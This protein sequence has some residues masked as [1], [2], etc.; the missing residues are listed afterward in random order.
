FVTCWTGRSAGFSPLMRPPEGGACSL[1]CGRDPQSRVDLAALSSRSYF[2]GP[3]QHRVCLAHSIELFGPYL[4]GFHS[5][6]LVNL[7]HFV[8][9]Q[10]WQGVQLM[11]G[12]VWHG[13][14][15]L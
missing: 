8:G 9:G 7:S 5:R 3:L 12:I 14:P 10:F 13:A 6:S 15:P 4:F 2:I 11:S 1:R